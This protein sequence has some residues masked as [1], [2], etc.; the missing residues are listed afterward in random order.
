MPRQDLP[1]AFLPNGAIYYAKA[2]YF[3]KYESFFSRNMGLFEM[4]SDKSLDIDSEDDLKIA[5]KLLASYS[6]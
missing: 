2:N 6:S 3:L 5:E 4:D 1:S